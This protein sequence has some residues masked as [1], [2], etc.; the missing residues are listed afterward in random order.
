MSPD[1]RLTDVPGF[2]MQC[3][4]LRH[5]FLPPHDKTGRRIRTTNSHLARNKR[6]IIYHLTNSKF[7][8]NLSSL[9]GAYADRAR[10]Q[11]VQSQN[12]THFPAKN[13]K[14]EKVL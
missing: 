1:E 12:R 9:S 3:E 10:L 4:L 6:L 7:H 13:L 5:A 14:L 8:A 11:S 2:R